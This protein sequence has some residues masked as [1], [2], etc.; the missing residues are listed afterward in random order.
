MKNSNELNTVVGRMEIETPTKL[1][2]SYSSSKD[3]FWRSG[4]LLRVLGRFGSYYEVQFVTLYPGHVH[5]GE[6]VEDWV[7]GLERRDDKLLLKDSMV[8]RWVDSETAYQ[9]FFK[10]IERRRFR[11]KCVARLLGLVRAR[12]AAILRTTLA[13][14][15]E[16]T[17]PLRS[18]FQPHSRKVVEEGKRYRLVSTSYNRR[19]R[20]LFQALPSDWA[21][22]G[23]LLRVAGAFA[24]FSEGLDVIYSGTNERNVFPVSMPTEEQISAFFYAKAAKEDRFVI[25]NV[26]N[27][28]LVDIEKFPSVDGLQDAQAVANCY[29]RYYCICKELKVLEKEMD[30]SSRDIGNMKAIVSALR[31]KKS[32]F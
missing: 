32:V 24:D 15:T 2:I 26:Q 25:K 9:E 8:L 4:C 18:L 11:E 3:R 7:A 21:D 6:P 20:K 12:Y 19:L 1:V 10:D 16:S 23:P 27:A 17:V 13:G 30:T 5:S 31:Y 29:N 14:I 28:F 22:A